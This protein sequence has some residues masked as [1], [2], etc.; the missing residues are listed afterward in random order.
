MEEFLKRI[1]EIEK[2]MGYIRRELEQYKKIREDTDLS[3]KAE[4]FLLSVEKGFLRLNWIKKEEIDRFLK[5]EKSRIE[6]KKRELRYR[7]AKDL[8]KALTQMDLSLKGQYPSLRAGLYTF[9]LDF[10]R[11]RIDVL[12]GPERIGLVDMSLENLVNL[13]DRFE[14]IIKTPF[15]SEKYMKIICQ[16]YKR[17]VEKKGLNIGERIGLNELHRELTLILQPKSF[18][19]NPIRRN[20]REYPRYRFSYDLYRLMRKFPDRVQLSIATFDATKSSENALWIPDS[21]EQGARYSYIIIRC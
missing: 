18:W 6:E 5:E 8:E 3:Y 14:K 7:F 16:G 13:I 9:K 19:I 10:A 15:D 11:G 2:G 21:E 1:R 20:F 12:W 17:V 4:E